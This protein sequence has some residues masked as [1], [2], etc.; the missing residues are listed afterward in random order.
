M[1]AP[2][3]TMNSRLYAIASLVRDGS[4]V[5]DIGTDHGYLISYLVGTGRCPSGYAC[6]LN[7]KPLARA[8]QTLA[9]HGLSESVK[10][11]CTDGLQGFSAQDAAKVQDI[12]IAGMGGDLIAAI[13][14]AVPWTQNP[15]L[16]FVLQPMTKPEHLR[17]ALYHGGFAI[18]HEKA[19]ESAGFV[20]TVLSVHYTGK[21]RSLLPLEEW[22]GCM[23]PVDDA[24]CVYLIRVRNL[25]QKKADGFSRAGR[26]DKASY[27]TAL[28]KAVADKLST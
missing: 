15:N 6:D 18:R 22:T 21:C 11:F 7:E 5:A 2:E 13:L 19:V 24:S 4:V 1:P 10:T 20:Y 27:Y 17:R 8:R 28:A 9:G 26:T 3:Y 25:L 23:E 14:T 16:N 12:V